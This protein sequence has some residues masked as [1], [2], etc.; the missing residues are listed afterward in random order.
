[1][2]TPVG[3]TTWLLVDGK[4]VAGRWNGTAWE[5]VVDPPEQPNPILPFSA[6]DGDEE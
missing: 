4:R 3:K 1:M 2:S 5:Q 6:S